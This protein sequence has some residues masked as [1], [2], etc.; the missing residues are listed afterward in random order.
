M[1]LREIDEGLRE[2]QVLPA[3]QVVGKDSEREATPFVGDVGVDS[4]A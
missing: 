2:T 4:N 1:L 3:R